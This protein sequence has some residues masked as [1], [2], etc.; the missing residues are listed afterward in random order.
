MKCPHCGSDALF[1]RYGLV[2]LPNA[3]DGYTADSNGR[4][5]TELI[6]NN[7][8]NCWYALPG[9]TAG[10]AYRRTKEEPRT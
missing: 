10:A 5:L 9:E 1:P 4:E 8:R 7:C 2:F 3:L 6:C